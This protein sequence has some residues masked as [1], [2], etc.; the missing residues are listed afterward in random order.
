MA[1][2]GSLLLFTA[3]A[4]HGSLTYLIRHFPRTV[5]LYR[6]TLSLPDSL[7]SFSPV[8]SGNISPL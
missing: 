8:M 7:V 2:R 4:P 1:E 3:S 5:D 6:V